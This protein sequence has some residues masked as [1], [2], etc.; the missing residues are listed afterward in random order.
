LDP[1][2]GTGTTLLEARSLGQPS[3]GIEINPLAAMIARAKLAWEDR[4]SCDSPDAAQLESSCPI[5][6]RDEARIYLERWFPSPTLLGIRKA[7]GAFS[8][9][10]E[11]DSLVAMTLL[12][13]ILRTY[14]WQ[15]PADLRIRRR[16]VIPNVP[17]IL[18]ALAD[19]LEF[20]WNRRRRWIEDGLVS[21]DIPASIVPGDSRQLCRVRGNGF[22]A[23]TVTS[24]PYACALPYVDTYRLSL[25][26]LGL[27]SPSQIGQMEYDT[28]GGRDVG[29]EDRDLFEARVGSLP[30]GG[31]K[32][33]SEIQDRLCRD[34]SAG[35]RRQAV[36]YALARYMTQTLEVLQ[37]LRKV[38]HS[39]TPNLWVVGANGTNVLGQRISIPTPNLIAELATASGFK[40]ASLQRLDAF[41]RFGV[42]SKNAIREET[43]VRFYG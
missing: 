27:A 10:G 28:I 6:L 7:L 23:G 41:R 20:E 15:D 14:S 18:A 24:P 3:E 5:A 25:V 26:A 42:H 37:E 43:L 11:A 29:K 1:F 9:F 32:L 17:P 35:F 31:R 40:D 21:A 34:K 33:V 12:S 22:V 8:L 16:E 4:P 2:A 38:E 36:P 13:N 30:D 19:A 39:G